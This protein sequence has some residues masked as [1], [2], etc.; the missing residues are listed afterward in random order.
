MEGKA[1]RRAVGG[2]FV[3]WILVVCFSIAAR[4]CAADDDIEHDDPVAPTQP[5]CSNTFV[6]VS[7]TPSIDCTL[8]FPYAS[9]HFSLGPLSF[10]LPSLFSPQ[11]G[12]ASSIPQQAHIDFSGVIK[13]TMTT[14]IYFLSQKQDAQALFL[15][16]RTG[17]S[18]SRF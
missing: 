3:V 13:A 7:P 4:P 6:L 10:F 16:S 9:I 14:I 17:I 2:L 1:R 8:N 15:H 18:R 5:G 11:L 12:Q